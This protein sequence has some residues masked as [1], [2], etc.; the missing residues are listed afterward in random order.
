MFQSPLNPSALRACSALTALSHLFYSSPIKPRKQ[1]FYKH[2]FW[3]WFDNMWTF[4]EYDKIFHLSEIYGVLSLFC[5]SR[6]KSLKKT[7]KKSSK[8]FNATPRGGGG[9]GDSNDTLTTKC[10]A[11]LLDETITLTTKCSAFLLD[12][13]PPCNTFGQNSDWLNNRRM[14]QQCLARQTPYPLQRYII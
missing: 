4:P 14:Q 6:S 11:F 8:K 9:G 7:H 10:S 12:E 13:T 2:Y 3:Q 5:A 1:H